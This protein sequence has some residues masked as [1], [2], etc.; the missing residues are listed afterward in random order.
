VAGTEEQ[1]LAEHCRAWYR[2]FAD[3]DADAIGGFMA[4]D[5]VL[6][7]SGGS[8]HER[9]K[10]LGMVRSGEL[11]HDEMTSEEFRVRVYGDAAVATV[12]GLSGGTWK[13]EAFRETERS[14][15]FFVRRN[16]RWLCVLTHLSRLAPDA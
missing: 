4:E 14:S 11:T 10:V 3:N 12:L 1:E 6:V 15:S 9:E 7:G 8:F 16:G 5:W 13:G 2:A